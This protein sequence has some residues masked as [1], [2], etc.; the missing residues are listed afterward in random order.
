VE[1]LFLG[2]DPVGTL[3]NALNLH[4]I[5]VIIHAAGRINGAPESVREANESYTAQLVAA[6]A[7]A[8]A[9]PSVYFLSS[10]S[11]IGPS[12]I[13]GSSKRKAE[14][15]IAAAG[16]SRWAI[17]RP[18]LIYGRH[19][20]K[21]VAALV[22]AARFWPIIPAVGGSAVKLQP[23]YV[24]DLVNAF[25]SLVEGKGRSGATYTVSGPR[26][27][28]LLDMIRTIQD[29]IGRKAPILPVSLTAVRSVITLADRI[30]PFMNLPVQQLRSLHDHPVYRSDDAVRDLGFA[31]RPFSD[32]IREYL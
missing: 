2:R 23:L 8:N 24:G 29:C 1:W 10:V 21:N 18:S 31:P 9:K 12:G 7:Q 16:F 15:M 13:Y 28:R 14:E 27:E 19:D 11:A 4:K 3:R 17:L 30:L 32:G 25:E 6:A 5:D 20:T 26:Q 22:R